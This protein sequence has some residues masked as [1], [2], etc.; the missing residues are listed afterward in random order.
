MAGLSG[1]WGSR[2][3]LLHPRDSHGRFR[4]KWKM[5]EG[6]VDAISNFLDRFNPRTFQSDNQ[7]SQ[8]LFNR[9]KPG[10]FSGGAGYPRLHADFDEANAHLR[11][12]DIDAPTQKFVKMMDDSAITTQE[13]LIISRTMGADSFGLTPQT[14]AQEDGGIEDFTARLIGERGFTAGVIGTPMGHGPGKVTMSIAVPKGTKL[15][16]PARSQTDRGVFFDRDQEFRVTKV[17]PDGRGGYYMMAIATPR[18]PGETPEP[19]DNGPRGVG[20]TP[21]QR[22][23]NVVK[24]QNITAK[25]ERIGEAPP[26]AGQAPIVPHQNAPTGPVDTGPGGPPPRN[27][28]IHAPSIGTGGGPAPSEVVPGQGTP[29]APQAPAAPAAPIDFRAAAR[30]AGLEWPSDGARRKQFNNAYLGVVDGKKHPEDALRQLEAD[31]RTNKD[32]LS[33]FKG[34]PQ[35]VGNRHREGD[36]ANLD[37]DIKKQEKLADLIAQQ[38]GLQRAQEPKAPTPVKA[39][40]TKVAPITQAPGE[41]HRQIPGEAGTRTVTNL[42]ARRAQK[43]AGPAVTPGAPST[44]S[45]ATPKM[46]SRVRPGGQ[47]PLGKIQKGDQVYVEQRNG[48]WHPTTRKTGST[49][50]TVDK[51]VPVSSERGFRKT[52]N[53]TTIV[54]HDD[55]GNEIRV[56]GDESGYP[57]I[58]TFKAVTTPTRAAPTKKAAPEAPA[59]IAPAAVTLAEAKRRTAIDALN[60]NKIEGDGAAS[61]K[62]ILR[63]VE[64][65]EWS[66]AKAR[67]EARDSVKH[68]RR[69]AEDAKGYGHA[70]PEQRQQIQ[71]KNNAIA[72]QY[73]K[74]AEAL[75]VSESVTKT[76]KYRNPSTGKANAPS[77]P[78]APSVPK[79]AAPKA[80]T[81]APEAGAKP[82]LTANQKDVLDRFLQIHDKNATDEGWINGADVGSRS[83][84]DTL[85]RKGQLEYM[86]ASGPRGGIQRFYRPSGSPPSVANI[87]APTPTPVP[88]AG[89][90]PNLDKMTKAE[91]ITHAGEQ[92]ITARQSWTKDKIKEAIRG[93]SP[94][95][96]PKVAEP[97]APAAQKPIQTPDRREA[98]AEDWINTPAMAKINEHTAAGR[99]ITEIRDDILSGKITPDEG[100]RRL[101]NDIEL[102]KAD[103]VD[104]EQE[105]RG[106][107][108]LIPRMRLLGD[109]DKLRKAI[110]DQENASSFMRK[111][112]R[113]APAVTPK[114]VEVQLDP[115][116]KKMVDA[117]KPDDIREA[118]KVAGFGELKGDTKDELLQDLV[119][120]IAGKELA[121]RA[122]KKAAPKKLAPAPLVTKKSS[123]PD[124]VDARAIAEGLG[125]DESDQKMLQ[126]VQ[127]LLDSGKTPAAAGRALN[128]MNNGMGSP[129]WERIIHHQITLE[130]LQDQV[131]GRTP[132]PFSPE[133]LQQ[134]LKE[135]EA[136]DARLAAKSKRWTDLADRLQ[137]TRRRPARKATEPAPEK[138]KLTPEENLRMRRAAG[139]LGVPAETLQ[140]RALARKVEAA[141]PAEA[142]K[143]AVEQMR[144]M[145]ST[146]EG[147]AFLKNRTKAELQ[148]IAKASGMPY[149]SK[150]TKTTLIQHLTERE[151][152]A[153]LQGE[154][155]RSVGVGGKPEPTGPAAPGI[156]AKIKPE[157]I[158][159]PAPEVHN[160]GPKQRL[161]DMTPAELATIESQLGIK[162][163]SLDR[164]DRIAAIRKAQEGANAPSIAKSLP[165]SGRKWNWQTIQE[166]NMV[167]HGDSASMNLA[168]KL[169]KAG[170]EDEAQY[171]ADMRYRISNPRGEH[172]PDDVEKMVKDLNAM[173]DAEQDPAIKGL[174]KRALSD[175]A[176]PET[177][178]PKLP[179]STPPVMRKLMDELNQIPVAR[180]TGHF[181]GTTKQVSAVDRLAELAQNVENGDAGSVGTVESE[182]RRILRSFHESV[183]GAMQMWRLETLI[184]D[185]SLRTWIR[186][187]YPK[188]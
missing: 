24:S 101:E 40:P 164:G 188:T 98:F 157:D 151:I 91:L 154:A 96:A 115:E 95:T 50:I 42:E 140:K 134:Q 161:E 176:A 53:R 27:E 116:A 44:T 52:T 61:Y 152:G 166:D 150:D 159:P 185:P 107:N 145:Q 88:E 17:T 146:D 64:T 45:E 73:E 23:A 20:L 149:A 187:F 143:T 184:D 59:K 76:D 74:L 105:L 103:L 92:G 14:L 15:I 148:E 104:V 108:D 25:R 102:N 128:D 21:A 111:H 129:S 125:M 160:Q 168:Q 175:I 177:A 47:I 158:L 156:H 54:G 32:S 78:K 85:V 63:N 120:K 5:A 110:S 80:P 89:A 30:D 117:A 113:Q 33:R 9:A 109:R 171:V 3:E 37:G 167:M 174:Y 84:L 31:I 173:M 180:R 8:Y 29:E 99:T 56:N 72:D 178:A 121:S 10:R 132:S 147:Q 7:S 119:K 1:A 93:A 77:A 57:G 16:I 181:A 122:A 106:D 62:N 41:K 12:G 118:A 43:A 182:I 144:T 133:E 183:D 79:K 142:A 34:E 67:K 81:P 87:N 48:K 55:Q 28:P 82:R 114:E 70:T 26:A 155:L 83:T 39:A 141:P 13:Q 4:S 186:S 90:A 138:P 65:G 66:T 69:N 170:R 124:Y 18:T 38:Y 130:K 86:E 75:T 127:E 68:W 165:D 100:I 22:E 112:F 36:I 137:K 19:I 123:D 169:H 126:H 153:R 172:S 71:D 162:R 135:A 46:E 11:A 94:A 6:V 131:A 97:N 179:E 2:E 136:K 51:R 60:E 58:Q 49:I 163:V 139:I 35:A